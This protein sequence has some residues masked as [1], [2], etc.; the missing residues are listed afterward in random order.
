M[1]I[2]KEDI[3]DPDFIQKLIVLLDDHI[4][5]KLVEYE[6]IEPGLAVVLCEAGTYVIC[7]DKNRWAYRGIKTRDTADEFIRIV[8][9]Y[10]IIPELKSFIEARAF[11]T[12]QFIKKPES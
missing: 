9:G 1:D 3:K 6:E 10:K 5:F 12:N 11:A 4:C 8:P 2:L 7:F